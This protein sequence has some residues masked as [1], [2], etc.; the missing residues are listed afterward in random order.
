MVA[1]R[2]VL[3]SFERLVQH[4][5]RSTENLL[6]LAF[7]TSSPLNCTLLRRFNVFDLLVRLIGH[8]LG[9]ADFVSRLDG[10]CLQ[11]VKLGVALS[12]LTLGNVGFAIGLFGVFC[13]PFNLF[14]QVRIVLC[15]G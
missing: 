1:K 5:I 8:M 15:Y 10:V 13:R 14:A 3:P 11:T 9:V 7:N 4:L 6:T 2:L 12:G